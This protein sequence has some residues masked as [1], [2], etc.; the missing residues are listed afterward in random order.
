RHGDGR[1]RLHVPGGRRERSGGGRPARLPR[2]RST[3]SGR[4]G[5]RGRH[6]AAPAG[7]GRRERALAPAGALPGGAHDGP[8][9]LICGIDTTK[10]CAP[11][12]AAGYPRP[13][14]VRF[15]AVFRA[16]THGM[17]VACQAVRL[18]VPPRFARVLPVINVHSK[19][20][21]LALAT[22]AVAA[23]DAAAQQTRNWFVCGGNHFDTCASVFVT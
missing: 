8:G 19:V 1:E 11:T 4:I 23:P 15:Q 5:G 20:L 18:V 10:I 14:K 16:R 6:G 22:L 17:P 9:A 21:V 2:V 13:R 3:P 12:A 7:R